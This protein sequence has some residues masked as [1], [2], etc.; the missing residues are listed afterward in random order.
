MQSK[1]ESCWRGVRYSDAVKE[2]ILDKV[3]QGNTAMGLERDLGISH[4]TI[5]LWC[6]EAGLK[7]QCGRP[8]KVQPC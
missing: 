6:D 7:L 8:R 4:Y 2:A 1:N 5:K 3:C